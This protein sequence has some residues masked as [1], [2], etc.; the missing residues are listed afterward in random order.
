MIRR[1]RDTRRVVKS[2]RTH[3]K[4]MKA[5]GAN[6]DKGYDYRYHDL[7]IGWPEARHPDSRGLDAKSKLVPGQGHVIQYFS[8]I[9]PS[10]RYR[11][12]DTIPVGTKGIKPG[13]LT[14]KEDKNGK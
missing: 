8:N 10:G 9:A 12:L 6:Y 7:Q 13:K 5:L 11:G 1:E 14:E 4:T 3:E 2:V